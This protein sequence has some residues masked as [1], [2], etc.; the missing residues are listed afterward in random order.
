MTTLL[1]ENTRLD[2]EGG[3]SALARVF[4]PIGSDLGAVQERLTAILRATSDPVV[5]EIVD[6]LLESPGKRIRPALSL[7]CAGAAG[8]TGDGTREWK[9]AAI[10]VAA[11]VELVHMASLIHDDVIDGAPIRH[12]RPSVPAQWGKRVAVFV[13]DHLCAKALQ[14]VAECSDP[15]LFTILGSQLAVMCVGELEQVAGRGDFGL[16]E[17]RCL[18][19]IEKKTASLFGAC[20]GMGAVAARAEP[21]VHRALQEFGFHVGIAFQILDDCK[22][23]LSDQ[24]RLGKS[25]GQDLWAGDVTLPLLYALWHGGGRGKRPPRRAS[26]GFEGGELLRLSRAFRASS[27]PGRIA[28]CV[29]S[30]VERARRELSLIADSEC[31]ASLQFFADLIAASVSSVLA[32]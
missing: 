17:D 2:R 9:R 21:K 22:D 29:R 26:P 5:R 8:G 7:L 10:D 23:L 31:K 25:P 27:A 13:G 4:R 19:V 18:A 1:G 28:E 11:A 3:W 12:H 30:Y 15:R 20:C 6:F 16:C 24:D 14:L 32:G